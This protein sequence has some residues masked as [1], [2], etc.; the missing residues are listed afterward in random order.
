[1]CIKTVASW[2]SI[3]LTYSNESDVILLNI[4]LAAR[5]E[6]LLWL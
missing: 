5:N 6:I 1:M 2:I 3:D 4:H